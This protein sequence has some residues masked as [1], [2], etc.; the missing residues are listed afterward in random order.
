MS[1]SVLTKNLNW[2]NL[3]KNLVTFNF[4]MGV[5]WKILFFQGGGRTRT[6]RGGGAGFGQIS[7]L[8]EEGGLVKK[9]G[10]FSPSFW[11]IR[12]MPWHYQISWLPSK[13]EFFR[14]DCVQKFFKEFYQ[15]NDFR[16]KIFRNK[17]VFEKISYWVE[18]DASGQSPFQK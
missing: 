3:I 2:E 17:K 7:D 1:L 9:D 10:V 8:K 5:H 18:T 6:K 11:K 4:I 14:N 15:T 16:L 13:Y 12:C